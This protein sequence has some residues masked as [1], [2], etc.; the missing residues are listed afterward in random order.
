MFSWLQK[1]KVHEPYREP[2]TVIENV[3]DFA[4]NHCTQLL[5][6]GFGGAGAAAA[7][8]AFD[9]GIDTIVIDRL[10]GGGA[11]R[12]SGGIF[13]AG[14]G[15]RVQQEAGE[16]DSPQNM[17]DYLTQETQGVV[18]DQTLKRFCD[19]SVDNYNWMEANGVRFSA[20]KCPYKVGYPSD[21]YF[22][23]YSGNEMASPYKEKAKPAARGHRGHKKGF[24]GPA[25]YNPLRRSAEKR[26]MTIHTQTK[27]IGLVQTHDSQVVG[28]KTLRMPA[29]GMASRMHRVID[30]FQQNFCLLGMFIPVLLPLIGKA[31]ERIERK[32]GV[33]TYYRATEGVVLS[34]GGF[35][36]NQAMVVTHAPPYVG[37]SPLGTATDDGSGIT[38]ATAIGAKTDLMH[39]V[40]AW[41]FINPPIAFMRGLMVG[42][43]GRRVCNEMLYGATVGDHIVNRHDGKAWLIIDQSIKKQAKTDLNLEKAMWFHVL[44]GWFYLNFGVKKASSIAELAEKM[45]IEPEQLLTTW[46]EYN[47]IADS[48]EPDPLGKDKEYLSAIKDGPYL[49]IDIGYRYPY[50]PCAS[51]TFGGLV[52]NEDTGQVLNQ[53]GEGIPGLYAAGR[54]A[55]G[56]ASRNYVSGLSIADCVFSGRRIAKHLAASLTLSHG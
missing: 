44:F 30:S 55:V 29:S 49:A 36:A 5:V 3:D 16:Q 15:T 50:V 39:T 52:V 28:V 32:H 21:N 1:Y 40:S 17:Y 6:A 48:G 35:F 27:L 41:R 2:A 46:Q 37:G 24:S 10:Q 20:Q 53:Q 56:V 47:Q 12:Q 8:E 13:Y 33:V 38:M 25:L 19:E 42:P 14:G 9:Q 54:A 45:N 22:L 18:S 51:I 34:T 31:L 4:W 43:S 23:Y 26:G 11:T 7:I